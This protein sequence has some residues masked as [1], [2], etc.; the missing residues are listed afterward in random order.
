M[1]ESLC[2]AAEIETINQLYFNLKIINLKKHTNDANQWVW[3]GPP[4]TQT[5]FVY[6]F[7]YLQTDKC[8]D[9][10]LVK[11]LFRGSKII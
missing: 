6:I 11:A 2:F 3:V 8:I 10:K 9:M 1:T 7:V 5:H 4:Q